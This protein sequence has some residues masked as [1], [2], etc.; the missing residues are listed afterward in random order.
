MGCQ[1][2]SGDGDERSVAETDSADAGPELRGEL[3][4]VRRTSA[5]ESV[6][7]SS[8]LTDRMRSFLRARRLS[9]ASACDGD[10]PVVEPCFDEAGFLSVADDTVA[11]PATAL[12]DERRALVGPDE[13]RALSLLAVDWW[14]TTAALRVSGTVTRQSSPPG[15][16]AAGSPTD[17]YVLD[18]ADAELD[19]QAPLPTLCLG[20]R[21][22][23]E[24][25]ENTR[26]TYDRLV[27]AAEQVICAG[28]LVFLGTP[29]ADGAPRI[30]P[31]TGR[32]GFVQV[33]D[34]HTLA[35]PVYRDA[36]PVAELEESEAATLL[37]PDSAAADGMVQ[38]SGPVS[39]YDS[40]AGATDP[41]PGDRADDWLL[42]DVERVTVSRDTPL[43]SLSVAGSAP[44]WASD[45]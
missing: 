20:E 34:A 45:G 43:P 19:R 10:R 9:V 36:V 6:P 32:P 17:W 44:P 15:E 16:A 24:P 13:R 30:T 18:V 29:T 27:A 11:W 12:A 35:W 31:L 22:G 39:R 5:V 2:D 3:D 41:G 8:V 25:A 23:R 1:Q 21:S 33:L 26:T 37:F 28:R 38:V 4:T 42:V 40:V 14:E 7:E